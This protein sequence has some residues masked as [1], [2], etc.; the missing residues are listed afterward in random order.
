MPGENAMHSA[1][2]PV[3]ECYD[4]MLEQTSAR[5]LKLNMSDSPY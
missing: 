1:L 5:K 2:T 4:F 3:Q